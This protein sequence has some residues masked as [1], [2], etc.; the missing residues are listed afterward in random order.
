MWNRVLEFQLNRPCACIKKQLQLTMSALDLV[1]PARH[2]PG[3]ESGQGHAEMRHWPGNAAKLND[4]SLKI[5]VIQVAK[6]LSFFP[7]FIL[8]DSLSM[9]QP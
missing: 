9:N 3:Y 6:S 7:V 8:I 2:M 4:R 1:Q 5:I